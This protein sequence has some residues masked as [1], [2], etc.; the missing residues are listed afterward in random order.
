MCPFFE[1][2]AVQTQALFWVLE[3]EHGVASGW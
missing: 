1:Q 2:I 3:T